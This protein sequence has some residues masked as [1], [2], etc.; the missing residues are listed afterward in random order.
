MLYSS[1]LAFFYYILEYITD[2]EKS[3]Q[4]EFIINDTTQ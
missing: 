1:F 3:R 2:E 4:Q